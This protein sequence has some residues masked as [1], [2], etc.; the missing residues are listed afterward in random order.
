VLRIDVFGAPVGADPVFSTGHRDVTALCAG[1]EGRLYAT[2]DA[3]DELNLVI[4]GADVDSATARPVARISPADGGL[5]G[6]AAAG[7]FVFLGALDGE[8]IHVVTVD[9]SGVSVEDTEE[10]LGGQYGRLRTVVLDPQGALWVT[11]SN[12]DGIGSP[13]EDDD[14][15]LRILPPSTAGDSPL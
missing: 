9:E 4:E 1:S 11:T 14:K 13:A 5:G 6:C 15:V 2:D 10:V 8:R 12:R 7:R 3:P